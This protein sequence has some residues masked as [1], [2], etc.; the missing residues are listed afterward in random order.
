MK[1]IKKLAALALAIMMLMGLAIPAAAAEETYD[2]TIKNAEGHTY[3]IYQ[4]FT[5]TLSTNEDGDEM[6]GNLK[7]GADYVPEGKAAG[8]AAEIPDDFDPTTITPTGAGTEMTTSGKTA[9]ATGLAAGYY[10]VVDVTNPL[11]DRDTRSAVIFQ[12][13]GDT[14]VTSKHNTSPIVEKKID[15]T[16]DSVD[17]TNEIIWHDSADHD[18]GDAIPFKL[19][20]VIPAS[21]GLFREHNQ[22]YPFT[23]HDTEE[24]GLTF[25]ESTVVVYVLDGETKTTLTKGT[26][27]TLDTDPSDG[28]TFDV[29]FSNL[30]AIDAVKAG[31]KLIVEYKSI[32]NENAIIGSKGN[33]NEVYGEFRNFNEPTEPKLTPKD[34][35]IAFTYKVVVNK[36]DE[37]EEPLE[38]A[39]FTLEK[40]N[41]ATEDWDVITR[42]ETTEGTIFTF[43]GLDD[44]NYRLTESKTPDGY[45]TI[46]PI[47]FTVTATHNIEWANIDDRL[48]ILSDLT[49]NVTTGEISFE[50]AVADGAL[51]TDVVNQSG[52]VLPET[53]GTGT[54]LFYIMGGAMVLVAAILLVTKK[55]MSNAD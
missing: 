48:T 19:E 18:I 40:Y 35:V 5:G 12:V 16:N 36:V 41:A 38:G 10:M 50:K 29:V 46:V 24:Q 9:T 53:G 30:A 54:T 2:V 51:T 55:R 14:E 33:V 44:G 17:A 8:D 27:Y 32:L 49:G 52:V 11:P 1:H 34:F 22:A 6:L 25:Q 15:D 47:E 23:F 3:K 43:N 42:V 45:N 7:Y 28:H 13:V 37:N 20:A 21:I 39:E 26:D 31:S 4:I